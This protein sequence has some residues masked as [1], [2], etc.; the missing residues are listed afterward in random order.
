MSFMNRGAETP[1][2]DL[3][4]SWDQ[5]ASKLARFIHNCLSDEERDRIAYEIRKQAWRE[6]PVVALEQKKRGYYL[7]KGNVRSKINLDRIHLFQSLVFKASEQV[8]RKQEAT[9]VPLDQEDM[10][11]RYFAYLVSSTMERCSFYVNLGLCRFVYNYEARE[12]KELYEFVIQNCPKRYKDKNYFR[13]QKGVLEDKF[14]ERFEGRLKTVDGDNGEKHFQPMDAPE[15]FY[16]LLQR[17]LN[18]FQPWDVSCLPPKPFNEHDELPTLIFD[19]QK[20]DSKIEMKR[21]HTLLHLD[22][23][24]RLV[25]AKKYEEPEKRLRLPLFSLNGN[26][27]AG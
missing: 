16:G 1:Q 15:Q 14:L 22:C 5:R 2:Y 11:V 9:G 23:F 25:R 18:E 20:D 7:P 10:L 17:C 26:Q 3:D 27:R 6:L 12:M 19:G 13:K 4:E 24:V 21:I 8:E